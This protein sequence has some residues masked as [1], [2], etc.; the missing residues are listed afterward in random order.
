[1]IGKMKNPILYLCLELPMVEDIQ[2]NTKVTMKLNSTLGLTYTHIVNEIVSPL[3]LSLITKTRIR[4]LD[5]FIGC[6]HAWAAVAVG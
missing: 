1:M 6:G 4:G 2:A 3:R 5:A